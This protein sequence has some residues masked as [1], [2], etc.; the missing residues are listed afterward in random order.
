MIPEHLV[1]ALKK[2]QWETEC[3]RR[4]VLN[5]VPR[6]FQDPV[7]FQATVSH[8]ALGG[9]GKIRL[10]RDL[11]EQNQETQHFKNPGHISECNQSSLR[12]TGA[13]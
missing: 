7:P 10:E 4:K 8:K 12:V 6:C 5:M 2:S 3:F 13:K 1:P 9:G 11:V